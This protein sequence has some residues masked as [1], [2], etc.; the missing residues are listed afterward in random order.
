MSSVAKGS[1]TSYFTIYMCF[2]SFLPPSLPLSSF[3]FS[4]CPSI[5]LSIHHCTCC[6][7]GKTLSRRDGSGH[8]ALSLVSGRELFSHW[9]WCRLCV[10]QGPFVWLRTFLRIPSLLRLCAINAFKYKLCWWNYHLLRYMYRSKELIRSKRECIRKSKEEIKV[11]Q[12]KLERWVVGTLLLEMDVRRLV[13][14]KTT[15]YF[16]Y[17]LKILIFY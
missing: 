9:V 4:F 1:C 6:A 14:I 2:L 5:H 17:I 13:I 11:L 16:G 10:S 12:Q 8:P 7:S 3:H 15:N